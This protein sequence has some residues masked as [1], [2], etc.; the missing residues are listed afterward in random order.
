MTNKKILMS[1]CLLGKRVRYDGKTL[2][3]TDQKLQNWVDR[4]WIVSV[5]PEVDAG[6]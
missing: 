1:A 4:G 6:M 5:C 2:K 3:V